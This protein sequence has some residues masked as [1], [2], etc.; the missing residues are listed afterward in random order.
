MKRIVGYLGLIVL[1]ALVLVGCGPSQQ[2]TPSTV[3]ALDLVSPVPVATYSQTDPVPT[4]QPVEGLE[5]TLEAV[6]RQVEPSVVNIQVVLTSPPTR[7]AQSSTPQQALGSGFVW[8]DQGHIVTNNHVVSGT[9]QI[10][11]IFSDG[12][13]AT[14]NVVGTDV[15]SDLAV[16]QVSGASAQLHPVK[17]GDS[18][19]LR[20]GQ[21][22][23]AIGNPFGLQGTMTV[24][25]ISALGRM[26]PSQAGQGPAFDIPQIIQTDAAINPGNSGGV[27]LNDQGEVIGVTAA[28]ASPIRGSVGLGFAIPSAIVSRVVPAL[29]ENGA[30]QH[31]YLGVNGLSMV[32]QIAE[33]MNLSIE[34]QGALVIDVAPGSPA[35]QAG[36]RGATRNANIEGYNIGI[37]GDIIVG[38]EGSTVTGYADLE[39]YLALQASP[40]QTVTVTVLRNGQ[41]Q[42]I[43]VTLGAV[44][45]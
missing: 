31:P 9:Q 42:S 39:T 37:G 7:G 44:A 27:L 20:V 43:D 3:Q 22:N 8:D 5:D 18:T 28:L 13:V 17:L 12:Y 16:I 32:P 1:V 45:D 34:Q 15:R 10:S 6:Y 40:G 36:I 38:I 30:Y 24:G 26:L 4:S 33:A 29:I 19:Q 35:A 21:L 14:A 25:Y 11:V 23:I 2:N 41:Q